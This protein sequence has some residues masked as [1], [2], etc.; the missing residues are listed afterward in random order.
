MGRVQ[1]CFY[2]KVVGDFQ[3]PQ[4]IMPKIFTVIDTR[5]KEHFT[6]KRTDEIA[7]G[8]PKGVIGSGERWVQSRPIR[9]PKHSGTCFIRGKLDTVV[10]FDD[11]TYGVI[12]FKTSERKAQHMPLYARQLHAYAY[13]LENAEQGRF[14]L[15]SVSKLGLLVFEPETFS[16]SKRGDVSLKG[17]LNWIEIQRDDRAFLDFIAEVLSMLEQPSPPEG[18]PTCEW[19]RYRNRSRQTKL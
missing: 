12:D 5:M 18:A 10:S 7:S 16:T 4:L 3:R 6:G 13:A 15:N 14:A 9:I 8:I 17:Q 19:C 11:G 2:L 1:R